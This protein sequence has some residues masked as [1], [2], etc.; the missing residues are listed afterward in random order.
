MS[1]S[2][3]TNR[4]SLPGNNQQRSP[5]TPSNRK[6]KTSFSPKFKKKQEEV[7]SSDPNK[8]RKEQSRAEKNKLMA[9]E[10]LRG[11][12]LFASASSTITGQPDS[13]FIRGKLNYFVLILVYLVMYRSFIISLFGHL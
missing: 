2:D 3:D 8:K 12:K 1:R 6:R 10:K 11:K 4:G 5:S 7:V 13:S 9:L